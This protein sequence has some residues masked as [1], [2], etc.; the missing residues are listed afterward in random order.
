M[1][2]QESKESDVFLTFFKP[3]QA[4]LCQFGGVLMGW[5][6]SDFERWERRFLAGEMKGI[7]VAIVGEK[8][9]GLHK[10]LC[11]QNLTFD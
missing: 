7:A 6:F 5:K 2:L 8:N 9:Q 4:I 1:V 3:F 10:H 11:E